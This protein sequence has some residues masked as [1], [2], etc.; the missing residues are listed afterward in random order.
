MP[1]QDA[2]FVKLVALSEVRG[3]PY[4]SAAEVEVILE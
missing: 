2:R 3:Q 1:L 4:A